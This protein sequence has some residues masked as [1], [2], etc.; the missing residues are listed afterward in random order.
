MKLI[1]AGDVVTNESNEELF[2]NQ[3]LK[4]IMG[5][6]LFNI[7][8]K[9]NYKVFNLEAPI[10]NS[11]NAIEKNGPNL[12]NCK[13]V[14]SG[15]KHMNPTCIMLANNHIMDYSSE[16]LQDTIKVLDQNDID[17]IGVGNNKQELKKYYI[18]DKKIGI[19][20]CCE[21]EFSNASKDICG[22]NYYD[23]FEIEKDLKALKDMCEYVIVIYHGGKEY[24]RY[25]SPMLQKRCRQMINYGANLVTCQHTHCVGCKEEYDKG[26][27]I[28]GQGNFIFNS[29]S[30]E[31]WD[32]SIL[33]NIDLEDFSIEYIPIERTSEGTKLAE[34]DTAKNILKG[35][36]ERSEQ[37][38]QDG[39]VE[40]EFSKFADKMILSYIYISRNYG[41]FRR[42]FKKLFPRIVK[43]IELRKTKKI[44][45][46]LNSIRCEA[47]RE[48]FI[49]G[50]ENIV[51]KK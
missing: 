11:M 25:P 46:L 19:Y 28:Y 34:P 13:N 7:W 14:I 33:L 27:I 5:E 10:T 17:W 50:L 12:K 30:D 23:E 6:E 42:V 38:K 2:S 24:Y 35:F 43:K 1:I 39:F 9:T 49:N 22:A 36:E 45:A 41:F 18:I 44:Y 15:I 16:G 40:E 47:H 37:I 48:V 51:N 29:R 20:N 8:N 32:T 3:E 21:T 4:K 31:F 26:T